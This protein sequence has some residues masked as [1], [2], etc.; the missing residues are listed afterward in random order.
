MQKENLMKRITP[1]L[2]FLLSGITLPGFSQ[3]FY[4]SDP[5]VLNDTINSNAEESYPLYS[6]IDSTLYFVRSLYAQ[7]TG[8]T[9]SGQDIWYSKQQSSG[10]W[11]KPANDLP[12]L[13]NRNNNAVVGISLT[14]NTLYLLNSYQ[15]ENQ[16]DPG[17]SFS[18]GVDQNWRAPN[19][20]SI[21]GLAEKV[22][23]Y[24]GMY[25]APSEDVAIVSLQ[26]ESSL[27]MEDLYVTEKDPQSGTWSELIH[28]GETVNTEGYEISP[29]LSK[30]K[31]TLFFA[32]NGHPGYGNADIFVSYRQDTSWTEWSKPENLGDGINSA[33]FDAYLSITE[34]N[35]VFFVSNRYGRST[36]IY[37]ARVISNEEREE[38]L[39]SRIVGGGPGTSSTSQTTPPQNNQD[40][41]ID[42]ETR[43][44]LEETQALL[45]EFKKVNPG[46]NAE[47]SSTTTAPSTSENKPEKQFEDNTVYFNL[48]SSQLLPTSYNDLKE[49]VSILDENPDIYVEVV[50]HADDSGGKDYNLKLSI[51]RAQ[52]VKKFLINQGVDET[53]IITYGKGATQP[54]SNNTSPDGRRQNRR[55]IMGFGQ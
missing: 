31:K 13:N 33:G 20:I 48:N 32:S 22:G 43:A 36:D 50:G 24:Y 27:G 35:S 51:E 29:F 2:L 44:L 42:E 30:D 25:V 45:D 23:N 34:N 39:A 55:V 16:E 10:Q 14:G 47:G 38:Q 21:P 6:A 5:I 7:N 4:F 52:S 37:Q 3:S 19:N 41:E 40:L 1:Y 53:R 15:S 18:F 46:Q 9:R 12:N 11:S 49:S 26:K 28:L 17:M 8:G 54:V